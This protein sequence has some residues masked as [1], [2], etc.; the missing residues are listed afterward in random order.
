MAN[1]SNTTSDIVVI[2]HVVVEDE[3][4]TLL[5][6]TSENEHTLS[7]GA[8][9]VQ[10][11]LAPELDALNNG[12]YNEM[13]LGDYTFVYNQT[14]DGGG[15]ALLFAENERVEIAGAVF[16]L[17]VWNYKKRAVPHHEP[18]PAEED[19]VAERSGSESGD[20]PPSPKKQKLDEHGQD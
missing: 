3:E 6:F 1:T 19:V 4:S 15:K 12:P 9:K 10:V 2:A 7:R 13:T 16:R 5:E 20:A 14:A 8:H 17:K 11:K 18:Q